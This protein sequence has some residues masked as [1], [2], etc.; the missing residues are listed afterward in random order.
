MP[1]LGVEGITEIFHCRRRYMFTARG[2]QVGSG[3]MG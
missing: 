3:N 2:G 1:P